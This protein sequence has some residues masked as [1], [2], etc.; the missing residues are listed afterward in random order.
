MVQVS[1]AVMLMAMVGATFTFADWRMATG[2]IGIWAVGNSRT[3]LNQ[4]A[5]LA[6]INIQ[7]ERFSPMSMAMAAW[8]CWSMVSG[9]GHAFSSMM[10]KGISTRQPVADY[11][12]DMQPRPWPWLM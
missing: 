11:F 1:L 12:G 5:L 3:S 4:R 2:S 9:S 7:P 10:A 8:I 6:A